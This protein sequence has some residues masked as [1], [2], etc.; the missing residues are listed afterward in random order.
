MVEFIGTPKMNLIPCVVH[1][2]E[3][4]SYACFQ[5]IQ[6]ELP[7]E[8]ADYWPGYAGHRPEEV[9]LERLAGQPALQAVV[10]LSELTGGDSYL[11]LSVGAIKLTAKCS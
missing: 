3:E 10:K 11:H 9:L 4:G 8:S 7:A 1:R 6:L 2:E 5:G